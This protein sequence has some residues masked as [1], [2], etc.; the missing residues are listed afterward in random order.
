[1]NMRFLKRSDYLAGVFTNQ[2]EKR[3]N[4]GGVSGKAQGIFDT[5]AGQKDKALQVF[6]SHDGPTGVYAP[7][8]DA[9]YLL[10]HKEM[11]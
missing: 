1:M 3:C 7:F 4:L 10:G 2:L 9:H 8:L 11:R 6:F 5:L